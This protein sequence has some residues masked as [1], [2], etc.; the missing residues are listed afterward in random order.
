MVTT[1]RVGEVGV[2]LVL[3]AASAAGVG[4]G[5]H[6]HSCPV[7]SEGTLKLRRCIRQ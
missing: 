5:V 3:T 7:L 1:L 2:D 4:V 6:Q